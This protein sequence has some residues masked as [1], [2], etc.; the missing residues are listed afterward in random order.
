ME[1]KCPKCSKQM[2]RVIEPLYSEMLPSVLSSLEQ[3]G[4]QVVGA[5]KLWMCIKC[6]VVKATDDNNKAIN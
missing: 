3:H 5:V 6:E 2:N 1:E 4:N